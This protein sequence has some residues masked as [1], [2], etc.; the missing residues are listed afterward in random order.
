MD[1]RV[2]NIQ[3]VTIIP[4]ISVFLLLCLSQDLLSCSTDMATLTILTNPVA[5]HPKA[6][7]K[8]YVFINPC[9]LSTHFSLTRPVLFHS[10]HYARFI[11]ASISPSIQSF[12][13]PTIIFSS[14]PFTPLNVST[15]PSLTLS[16]ALPYHTGSV[17]PISLKL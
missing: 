1:F 12:I 15:A 16:F 6:K 10:R 4:I 7:Q 11:S 8:N 17:S 9:L 5:I 3:I 13:V 2:I 14:Y